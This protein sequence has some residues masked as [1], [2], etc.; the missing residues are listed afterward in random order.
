MPRMSDSD[1]ATLDKADVSAEAQD[2]QALIDFLRDRDVAC[3]LCRYNLRG[4]TS[5]RCRE[6]ARVCAMG[7]ES[8]RITWAFQ[9]RR[10]A[11]A[12]LASRSSKNTIDCGGI[13]DLRSTC[14]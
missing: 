2:A 3:P 7:S 13:F 12:T 1:T 10:W 4:L 9:P 6:C 5:A 11:A 8:M 14:S